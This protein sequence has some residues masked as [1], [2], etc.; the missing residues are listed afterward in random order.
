MAKRSVWV[1]GNRSEGYKVRSEGAERA[2]STH[3]TQSAAIRAGQE[4][5]QARRSE[6]IVQNQHGQIRERASYGNDPCP[7]RDRK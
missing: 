7:P 6:L 4:V 3:S 2:A 1:V 5:A